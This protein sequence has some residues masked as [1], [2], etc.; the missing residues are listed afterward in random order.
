MVCI[1]LFAP[2]WTTAHQSSL[3]I[4][5]SWSLLKL[6]SIKLGMPSNYLILYCPLLLLPAIFLS[7]R[8]FSSESVLHIKRPKYWSFS[9]S[10]SPSDEYSELIS[11]RVDGFGLLAVQGQYEVFNQSPLDCPMVEAC[12]TA[13]GL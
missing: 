9:F 11:C 13:I 6:M 8:V 7:I 2:A 10:I 12:V 4:T 3:S 1:R 5:I